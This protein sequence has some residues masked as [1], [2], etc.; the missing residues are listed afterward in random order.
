MKFKIK[1]SVIWVAAVAF[2]FPMAS[3]AQDFKLFDR[4]FQVHGFASQGFVYTNENNWLTMNTSVGSGS[5]AFTDFGANISV[6]ITSN[7]RVGAQIY[8]RNYGQLGQWHPVLDWAYA[9]YKFKSWLAIR[10]GKVKTVMG[11]FNDTQD[12]NFL[13]PFVLLPQSIYPTD[14]R[15]STIAHTGGDVYGEINLENHLGK[16]SY[17]AYAGEREDSLY[18]GY[19]YLLKTIP[20]IFSS[21]GGL[22]YGGDLRW[23]TPLKGLL[24]GASRLDEDITGKG[25]SS[26]FGPSGPYEEHSISDWANQFYGQYTYGNLEVDAEWRRYWRNQE[27][28]NGLTNVQTDVR[29]AYVAASYRFVKWFQLGSYYSRYTIA[30]P[31]SLVGAATSGHIFDTAID[32]RFD[33]NR[34]VNIKVEGHFM[35]GVGVPGQYP[36]GFYSSDNPQGLKPTTNALILN[37]GFNF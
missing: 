15:D 11:L 5:A 10:G 18:G 13:H 3:Y 9:S 12:L 1:Q 30:I 14:L 7:F 27:I 8:D 26:L 32:G 24:V 37:V 33:L 25:T 16:L 20:I 4:T 2:L 19:P 17:T 31:A 35:D 6:P 34:F 36:S 29:G 23:A 22:Q 28:F 21:Y